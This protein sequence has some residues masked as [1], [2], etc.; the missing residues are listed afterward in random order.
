MDLDRFFFF[1]IFL[2]L[3]KTINGAYYSTVFCYNIGMFY[4]IT[5]LVYKAKEHMQ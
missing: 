1:T 3:N 5:C 2:P 4:R